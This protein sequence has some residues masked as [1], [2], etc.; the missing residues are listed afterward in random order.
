MQITIHEYVRERRQIVGVIIGTTVGNELRIGWSKTNLKAG[1]VFEKEE[2]IRIA[3][4]RANGEEESPELPPQMKKQMR[5]FQIRA[6]RYFKQALFVAPVN[7]VDLP[8][9]NVVP[10]RVPENVEYFE[11]DLQKVI[12]DLSALAMAKLPVEFTSRIKEEFAK[13]RS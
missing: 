7:G 4:A 6:L 3:L 13:I 12:D 2:G 5:Q 10:E 9:E 8:I 1:D 11:I